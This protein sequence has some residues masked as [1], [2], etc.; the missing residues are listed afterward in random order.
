MRP[1][2]HPPCAH[3]LAL[4]DAVVLFLYFRNSELVLGN[5]NVNKAD[6]VRGW[7][8]GEIRRVSLF[9]DEE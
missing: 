3:T 6:V 7:R 5:F 2:S 1:V 8:I 9:R 4:S